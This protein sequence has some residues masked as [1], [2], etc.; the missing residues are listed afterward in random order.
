MTLGFEDFRRVARH[1]RRVLPGV[2][3]Q[4]TLMPALGWNLAYIYD[5]PTPLAVGLG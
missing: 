3:L 2:V 1:R 4:Y 5:L